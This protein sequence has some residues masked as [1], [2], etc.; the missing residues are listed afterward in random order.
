M[1][2]YA[3]RTQW[4]SI[5]ARTPRGYENYGIRYYQ[6]RRGVG[7]KASGRLLVVET[8]LLYPKKMEMASYASIADCRMEMVLNGMRN[9][10]WK[11]ILPSC[12]CNSTTS[13]RRKSITLAT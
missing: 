3:Q 5:V 2:I 13:E 9:F 10:K 1:Y 8:G 11:P 4:I 6:N 7:C 12:W